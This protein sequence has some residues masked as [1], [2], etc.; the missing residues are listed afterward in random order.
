MMHM[1]CHAS[2]RSNHGRQFLRGKAAENRDNAV[3]T[4]DRMK[5]QWERNE[6][7]S[8]SGEPTSA[9]VRD[10]YRPAR[11]AVELL[12]KILSTGFLEVMQN[13]RAEHD[14][15]RSIGEGKRGSIGADCIGHA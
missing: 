6:P 1:R 3:M 9:Q 5:T 12:E 15:D 7:E 11:H 8:G 14:V 4:S 13:L 2:G 10:D